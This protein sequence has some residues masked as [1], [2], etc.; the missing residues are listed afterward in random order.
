[1][2]AI[3]FI[4]AVLTTTLVASTINL[5]LSSVVIAQEKA[6]DKKT[7]RTPAM[8]TRVYDQLARAQSVADEG[9]T[10]EALDILDVV[11]SKE[12][13]MN[14]YEIAMLQN[15][16]G[17]IYYN[18]ENFDKAIESFEN[19]VA[20]Q[21]IPEKF[22]QSTL[23][24]LAQL[25]MMR[26]NYDK[27]IEYLERWEN[28]QAGKL[29]VKNLVL[30][31]QA[32]YQKKDYEAASGYIN[33]AIEQ[34]ETSDEGYKVDENWYVLQRAIYYELKQPQKVTKVLEKMV[35]LFDRPDY[36]IQLAGM[37]GELGEEKKQLAVLESAYQQDY[38][39]KASD[40][41]NLAQLYYYH[42]VPYKGARLME[43]AMQNGLLEKN[44][45]NLKFLAQSWTLAKENENA[46]PVMRSAAALS[47][48]GELDAQLS[49]LF[50]N[51]ERYDEAI[52]SALT[53]L[54][55]GGLRNQGTTHLVLGMAYFNNQRFV[56]AL[57]QL[58][59]AEKH[60]TSRGM[61]QQW[62]KFVQSEKSS[63]EQLQAELGSS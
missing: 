59:E 62:R 31:A 33:Q 39:S 56:D 35:K 6:S 51:L 45:R 54:D 20:Q 11:A 36:W 49:Q 55:K 24:S 43:Q 13:S 1:M 57:N 60:P 25:H 28:L 21:P 8:R 34:Q 44:L 19:V 15:F 17:F 30:K 29:P 5:T 3:P 58:A 46:V 23:F 42:Q 40:I 10:Q 26:G 41:F 12:T 14:S 32:M 7:K 16:Y 52:E 53:A 48:D 22:E 63:K 61:A 18:A 27:T 50:L 4:L 37:Y 47:E 9:K 38:I 2:K